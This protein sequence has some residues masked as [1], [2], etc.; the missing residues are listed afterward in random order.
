MFGSSFV[1]GG[2]RRIGVCCSPHTVSCVALVSSIVVCVPGCGDSTGETPNP[3]TDTTTAPQPGE[4][5]SGEPVQPLQ[6]STSPNPSVAPSTPT[7]GTA[8]DATNTNPPALPTGSDSPTSPAN[9]SIP[10]SPISETPDTTTTDP[11]GPEPELPVFTTL[12]EAG[13]AVN[14]LIGVALNESPLANDATYREI[15]AREFDY[16][17]AENA[18]KWEPLQPSS[19]SSYS[20]SNADA[21]VQFAQDN[22][23][24]VKGHTF[25]WYMQNP[26]W[27]SNLSADALRT[28]MQNHIRATMTRYKG[29]VRAW[30]VVNEAVDTDAATG[31]RENVFWQA[32]GPDY[33]EEAFRYADEVRKEIDPDVLLFYNEIGIERIGPKSDFAYQMLKDL[34]ANG[35]PIDGIGLQSHVSTHRY[36]S[37]ADLRTNLERFGKLGLR[38]NISEVDVRDTV[39][40]GNAAQRSLAQRIAYQQIVAAC[41][42]EP[43]CE[44][45][46]FW[47]FTD[48]Y[49][50]LLD[51]GSFEPLLFTAD[52]QK[53][54]AYLGVLDGLRGKLPARGENLLM[55]GQFTA[56]GENW[57][58]RGG[59]LTVGAA[60]DRQG[61]AACIDGRTGAADGL[62][63]EGLLARAPN[64][65]PMSFSAWVRASADSTVDAS[66]LVE[67]SGA[68]ATESNVATIRVKAST[69][70]A[71][72]GYLAVGFNGVATSLGLKVHGPEGGVQ[73]C[74][75]DVTL[76][77]LRVE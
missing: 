3:P 50:W 58:S 49:S 7:D 17:T 44:A 54:P 16:V 59:Q 56:N 71:L 22:S 6:P 23:Q 55:N 4:T 76:Q 73:L 29:K 48:A 11:T 70:T 21:I 18:M 26:T 41:V 69:W 47:G 62:V 45:I 63:Q 39:L 60:D 68:A 33:V 10:V 67:E 9:P 15:A 53:K 32:L 30:D 35:V 25:V 77:P 42:L 36:P 43:T 5:N 19:S 51:E 27:A 38:V 1:L 24:L 13:A 46:T 74:V 40:P 61:N 14:R 66:I 75:A 72:T 52:Y 28:A 20:W 8:T 37:E 2:R 34:V 57:S 31:Y 64:G 12:K 65:G